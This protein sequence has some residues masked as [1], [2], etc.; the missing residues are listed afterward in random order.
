VIS[1]RP[2]V[3]VDADAMSRV[4]IVSIT[5][6]CVADHGNEP[7]KLRGWLANKTP[8]AVAAWFDNPES[9]LLVAE[10]DGEIAA[11]GGFSRAREIMLNYVAPAFRGVGVTSALLADMETQLGPGI[12]KLGSTATALG[13]YRRRGW[14][15]DGPPQIWRGITAFPLHKVL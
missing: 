13:F 1:V 14:L 2:A 12:A 5:K 15:D 3:R 8:D 10:R 9:R 11:V 6:L 4:L 7:E